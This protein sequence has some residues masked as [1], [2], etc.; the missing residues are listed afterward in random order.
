[1]L[2]APHAVVFDCDG[3]LVDS[4]PLHARA[5]QTA[6]ARFK[7]NL[8]LDEIRSQ[9][10]GVANSDFLKKVADDR[11]I[12]LPP[13]LDTLVEDTA[14]ELIADTIRPVAVTGYVVHRLAAKGIR[15][16]VA[17][18]SSRR[19]V[20][21]ILHAAGLAGMFADRIV[22]R[23]DVERPKPAADIYRLVAKLL[24]TTGEDCLAIED[25]PTGICSARGAGMTVIGYRPRFSNF[26]VD[27][28]IGAGASAVIDDLRALLT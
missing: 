18:N 19:F 28:L 12:A 4:E 9:G 20:N 23:D 1:M 15:V 10:V 21:E 2:Y 27:Q 16:A 13:A 3:T 24:G 5:L 11:G 7:V 8:S 14:R 6:L 26:D 22:T 25:S 17:S